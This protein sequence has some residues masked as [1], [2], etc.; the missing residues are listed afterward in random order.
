MFVDGYYKETQVLS[1]VWSYDGSYAPE[2]LA[3]CGCSAALV[4]SD[5]PLIKPIAGVP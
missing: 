2:P 3:I 5:I 1:Y 4:I